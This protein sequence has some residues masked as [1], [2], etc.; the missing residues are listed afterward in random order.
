MEENFDGIDIDEMY[1]FLPIAADTYEFDI[2]AEVM[3]DDKWQSLIATYPFEETRKARD[4]F[5]NINKYRPELV[6]DFLEVYGEDHDEMY[7]SVSVPVSSRKITVKCHVDNDVFVEKTYSLKDISL[8]RNRYLQYD[9]DDDFYMLYQ[10][11]DKGREIF[12]RMK[13]DEI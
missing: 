1:I 7:V 3:L 12:E 4:D 10:L 13:E 5:L 9:P 8:F 11:T 2:S 6:S